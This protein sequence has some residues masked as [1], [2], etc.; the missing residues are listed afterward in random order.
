MRWI[1]KI[2]MSSE[3]NRLVVAISDGITM[4]VFTGNQLTE[5]VINQLPVSDHSVASR[6][7]LGNQ[8]VSVITDW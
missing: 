2:V 8:P 1:S 5:V 7:S 3:N 6:L 4:V